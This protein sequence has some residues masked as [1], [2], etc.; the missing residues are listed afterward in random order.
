MI[1]TRDKLRHIKGKLG[2]FCLKKN[3]RGDMNQ[4]PSRKLGFLPLLHGLGCC[5]SWDSFPSSCNNL[6]N[7]TLRKFRF[8][9]KATFIYFSNDNPKKN[10]SV[11]LLCQNKKQNTQLNSKQI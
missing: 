2:L 9:L 7:S 8:C 3:H 11:I 6:Y 10:C 5:R 1:E 4:I